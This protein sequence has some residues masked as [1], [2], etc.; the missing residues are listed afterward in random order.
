MQ[1][2]SRHYDHTQRHPWMSPHKVNQWLL[3]MFP[4]I[5]ASHLCY[6]IHFPHNSAALSMNKSQ[7]GHRICPQDL[8]PTLQQERK[9]LWSHWKSMF[10]VN[11]GR[12]LLPLPPRSSTPCF[13]SPIGISFACGLVDCQ[14][15]TR[16]AKPH[17]LVHSRRCDIDFF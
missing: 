12:G 2:P 15:T 4:N 7:S 16:P 3:D 6:H 9:R 10:G 17:S 5:I 14:R 8:F 1:Q 11:L 13:V